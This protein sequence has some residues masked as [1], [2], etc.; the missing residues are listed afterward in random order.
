MSADGKAEWDAALE[1]A[2]T[3]AKKANDEKSAAANLVKSAGLELTEAL[4]AQREANTTLSEAR[5]AHVGRF[6]SRPSP[7][8]TDRGSTKLMP[9]SN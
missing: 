6:I 5:S 3:Q 1:A 9:P 4:N 8:S 2:E 7:P